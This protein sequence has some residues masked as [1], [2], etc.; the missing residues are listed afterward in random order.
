MVPSCEMNSHQLVF[1]K[2]NEKEN[3]ERHFRA[4]NLHLLKYCKLNS[5]DESGHNLGQ[6]K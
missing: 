3:V 2:R 6:L 1:V 5:L 4:H